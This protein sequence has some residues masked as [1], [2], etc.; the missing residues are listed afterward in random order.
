MVTARYGRREARIGDSFL[1]SVELRLQLAAACQLHARRAGVRSAVRACSG[2]VC[3]EK[4]SGAGSALPVNRSPWIKDVHYL[5][6]EIYLLAL[7]TQGGRDALCCTSLRLFA[8]LCMA[9]D[10]A[11]VCASAV[12]KAVSVALP[13]VFFIV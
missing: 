1:C 13:R 6:Y 10:A 4:A 8:L 2:V 5:L 7:D 9:R 3:D 11:H 12:G